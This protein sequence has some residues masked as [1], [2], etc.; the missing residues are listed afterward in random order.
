MTRLPLLICGHVT[1]DL[2]G[3][4]RQNR[5]GGTAAF[6]AMAASAMGLRSALVTRAPAHFDL[7]NTLRADALI[8]VQNIHA[9]Q[10]TSFE[11]SYN[12]SGR[13]LRLLGRAPDLKAAHIPQHLRNPMLA[14]I[15]SV[16]GECDRALIERLNAQA[17]VACAQ[18]WL[19]T[20]DS[21]GR[22][23]PALHPVIA[24]PPA[25]ID[26]VVYSELDH[27]DA[28]DIARHLASHQIQVALTRAKEGVTLFLPE[29]ID[30]PAA[31]A[32][33]VDP[34]GAGDVFGLV[35]GLSLA[36]GQDAVT[37][38]YRAAEAAARV[39]EGPGLGNLASW[40]RR[41]CLGEAQTLAR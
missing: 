41:Q 20:T 33:E 7:L 23:V 19:R 9:P 11:L 24:N 1:R 27:P 28:E 37:A 38:A 15:A 2:V 35:F 40:V 25:G 14:Y 26:A 6:A 4:E 3:P 30:I 34:T 17:T 12:S 8:D 13:Q 18:G 21:R 10:E 36:R 31:Q 22:V 29:V 16:V 39:V 5:L 32:D